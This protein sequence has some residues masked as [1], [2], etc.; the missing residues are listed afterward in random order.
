MSDQDSIRTEDGAEP[1]GEPC[2]FPGC[3]EPP[4]PPGAGAGRRPGFCAD[5]GHTKA[6]AFRERRRLAAEAAAAAAPQTPVTLAAVTAE[7][8][9]SRAEQLAA[10]LRAEMDRLVAALGQVTDPA[11][12]QMEIATVTT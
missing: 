9:L 7:V 11:S 1:G 12:A 5:P 6:S 2:R 10:D 3:E 4:E 8:T